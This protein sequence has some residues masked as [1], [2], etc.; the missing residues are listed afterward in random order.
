MELALQRLR[1]EELS[2]PESEL[3]LMRSRVSSLLLKLLKCG[4]CDEKI[5]AQLPLRLAYL[6]LLG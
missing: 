4:I 6:L 1:R 2:E 3:M 5:D